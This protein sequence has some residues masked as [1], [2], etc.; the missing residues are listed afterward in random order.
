M[1]FLCRLLFYLARDVKP[2]VH[3]L[4]TKDPK[5]PKLKVTTLSSLGGVKRMP[6]VRQP[7]RQ[8]PTGA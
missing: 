3:N 7:G 1:K 8:V 5:V 2:K 6:P 4:F